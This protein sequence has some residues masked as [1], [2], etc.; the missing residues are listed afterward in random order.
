MISL[1]QKYSPWILADTKEGGST[2]ALH[3]SQSVSCMC[4]LGAPRS[5]RCAALEVTVL[6]NEAR[7]TFPFICK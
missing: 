7:A 5:S 4:Y 1:L 6:C 3:I 2:K